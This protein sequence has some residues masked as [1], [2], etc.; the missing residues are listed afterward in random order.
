MKHTYTNKYGVVLDFAPGLDL[1]REDIDLIHQRCERTH[2]VYGMKIFDT[3]DKL[4]QRISFETVAS[5]YFVAVSGT[6]QWVACEYRDGS[7]FEIRSCGVLHYSLLDI[8][9]LQKSL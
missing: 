1:S 5:P 4:P 6:G 7:I 2:G 8:T 9:D 3:N